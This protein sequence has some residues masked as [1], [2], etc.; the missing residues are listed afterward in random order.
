MDALSR[1]TPLPRDA[2][3]QVDRGALIDLRHIGGI[4]RRRWMVLCAAMVAAIIVAAAA[5][6]VAE[7][8][9]LATAQVALE[10]TA[11]RVIDVDA[12]TPTADPDSAAVD[13]EVQA[14]RSPELI[15]R[16]VD[17]LRLARDPAFNEAAG[18]GAPAAQ[19]DLIGRQRAIGTLLGRLT[20]KRDGL[21]Y[22]ISVSYEGNTPGQAAQIANA[23][24]DDYVSGQA[25]S[26]AEATQRAQGFLEKRLEDLR[27][28]VLG[29]ERA[30]ADYRAAHNLFAVSEASTVTQQELSGLSTQLAQAKA[31]NAAAQA[32]LSAARAQVRGG[33]SGEELGD[34]LDSPVVSQ[35]R[36]QRAEAARE[37]AALEKRYG[38][39]HP[40]LVQAQNQLRTADQHIAAEV[41]RIVANA[42]IQASIA[43]QRAASLAGSVAQ[44]QGKLAS[45]NEA[46][47]RLAELE[48]NA[49]SSRT[50]YQAFLDRYRQTVAQSGL[51]R[52]D[53]YIVSRAR[54]PG[55]PSSPNMLIYAAM[56]VV[57][58]LGVGVLLV[59]LLQLLERGLETSD[60]I[61]ET[62]GLATLAS[63]PDARTLPG[64]RK[65][66]L[67]APPAELLIKRPQ[68]TY[69]EAFRALR[70]SIQ[71]AEA[72]QPVRVVAITSAVP[73]EGKT[74]TAMG[75]ARAMAA[76]GGKVLLIDADARRRASSR[77]FAEGVTL[78]LDEVL[79]GDAT[80]DQAIV[81]DSMSDA[82]LLPQ[83]L[84]SKGIGLTESPALAELIE[85][86]RDRYD[87]V[88]LDTPPVLPVDEARVIA[89]MADGVVFLVRWRKTPSKAA[90]VALRRL[91][92]VHAEMLGAVLT[93]VDVREQ[94]RAGYEDGGTFLK[95]YRHYYAD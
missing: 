30:V 79:A 22:A 42:S 60:A 74:T 11:E 32:R 3:P 90:S 44:T 43:G 21:S 27:T 66:G 94:E 1:R 86:V 58:G 34:S 81:K 29:A 17:R 93:L 92:D 54:V 37:V 23:L 18:Q 87:L 39:R 69:A 83:R 47:V 25:G 5:Y 77:Q 57:G 65:S 67:P 14:L 19:P 95:A 20:V 28:Q 84:D 68:S 41:K 85:Q 55:A 71:F 40:A 38:P 16:V 51:E 80:L 26:K 15:G 88:I 61:E 56:A 76:A 35:L 64:Y 89:S 2:D 63:I 46:S 7:P 4:L 10:R 6:L 9:Y 31:E 82:C 45:D 8:R 78:G 70:T 12:V 73:G 36:A 50:L 24:V 53:S 13:T 91:Y 59:V 48:R 49:E 62:L 33:R 52:S 75:L 72:A